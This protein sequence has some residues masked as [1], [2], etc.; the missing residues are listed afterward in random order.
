MK[1]DTELLRQISPAFIHNG[2]VTSQ[3]F[4][5]TEEHHFN[6][7]LY[8][9]ELIEPKASWEHYTST[10]KLES[11]GVMAITAAEC[12]S[13]GLTAVPSPEVFAEHCHVDF[14]GLA[15]RAAENKS[16]LLRD[17]AVQRNWKFRP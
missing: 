10:F 5:P 6:L 11:V 16:R 8:D 1:E 15:R 13:V 9:G 12:T 2:D 7:S 3:A 17:R 4:R 14:S